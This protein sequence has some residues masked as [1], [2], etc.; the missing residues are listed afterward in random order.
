MILYQNNMKDC[1]W[2]FP[3][4]FLHLIE[5]G[6]RCVWNVGI[7]VY[8][9]NYTL[10]TFTTCQ[11]STADFLVFDACSC[12]LLRT[13]CVLQT[14]ETHLSRNYLSN[15]SSKFQIYISCSTCLNYNDVQMSF[16]KAQ[17]QWSITLW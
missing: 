16:G 17:L 14:S 15:Y 11:I 6:S 4:D 10:E 2:A 9:L 7:R 1:S 5:I 13:S 12:D 3:N 8:Y